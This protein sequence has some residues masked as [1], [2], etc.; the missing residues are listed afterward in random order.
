MFPN[1]IIIYYY[2]IIIYYIY[3]YIIIY[4]YYIILYY[5]IIIIIIYGSKLLL[6]FCMTLF[7]DE[8]HHLLGLSIQF[9]RLLIVILF[10]V[11][12]EI[13]GK[14]Y[15]PCSAFDIHKFRLSWILFLYFYLRWIKQKNGREKS[16]W[17]SLSTRHWFPLKSQDLEL[18]VWLQGGSDTEKGEAGLTNCLRQFHYNW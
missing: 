16:T 17:A 13:G 3:I 4:I 14:A 9:L 12:H 5:I 8:C 18:E 6:I 2:Y 7:L 1:E 15:T 10:L 11:I